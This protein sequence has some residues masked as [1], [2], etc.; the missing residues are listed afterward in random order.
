MSKDNDFSYSG[1]QSS[2]PVLQ[3]SGASAMDYRFITIQ[4]WIGSTVTF[5]CG[6]TKFPWI[7]INKYSTAYC[8]LKLFITF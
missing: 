2:Y 7:H 6:C 3:V 8:N 5:C 1:K 4:R